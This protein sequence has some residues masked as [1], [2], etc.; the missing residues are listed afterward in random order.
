MKRCP[1]CRR[2]YFDDTLSYCLDDGTML[3]EG[4]SSLEPRTEIISGESKR[5]ETIHTSETKVFSSNLS[6]T[7]APRYTNRTP[8]ITVAIVGSLMLLS[9]AGYG[10]Y[11]F[12]AGGEVAPSQRTTANIEIQR[13][14][15]DGKTRG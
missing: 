1:E 12:T 5:G 4:P 9:A 3:L 8:I 15:G 11:R 14:T 2:D 6:A 7:I 10:V 13:L